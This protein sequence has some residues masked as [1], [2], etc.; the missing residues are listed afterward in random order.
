MQK[1]ASPVH[2]RGRGE[3][4]SSAATSTLS[5]GS[6]PRTRGTDVEHEH[7]AAHGRFIPADAGNRP[8]HRPGPAVQPVHP[9]GRGEQTLTDGARILVIGS[10]PRTRGT[11]AAVD[12][13]PEPGRFIP[14]DA[15]NS[16]PQFD[17]AR[18]NAVHPRGRGEQSCW[19]RAAERTCG[20]SPRTRGTGAT[21][22]NAPGQDRFIPADAGN[23]SHR[24]GSS[25]HQAVHP[26][27]RGEQ[28]AFSGSEEARSGSSPRTRGTAPSGPMRLPVGRFIPADAGNRSTS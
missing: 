8:E 24:R 2:P 14:A 5:A 1:C 10:S 13:L 3:Q 9:R 26:R 23:R 16:N 18:A 4:S 11:V 20:S 28:R 15:G 7:H 12:V 27:G 22:D 17:Q 19:Y 6:S 21:G 25:S